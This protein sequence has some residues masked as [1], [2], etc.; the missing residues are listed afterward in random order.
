MNG[1]GSLPIVERVRKA[2]PGDDPERW[3]AS[4]QR[5]PRRRTV[6]LCDTNAA[7][8]DQSVSRSLTYGISAVV[9]LTLDLVW[10]GVLA[11]PLYEP[12]IGTLLRPQP[13][14]VAAALFYAVYLVGVNELVIHAGAAASS[15]ARVAARG[16]LL[17]VVAY[18][19]FDL[20]ALAVLAGWSVLVTAV[21]IAWGA[22]LTAAT[23]GIAHAWAAR[24][25][26]GS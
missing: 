8:G 1:V 6:D 10:L 2:R 25:K 17:G 14:L 18:S 26:A 4:R 22:I 12:A 3:R 13:N 24:A 20:T 9:M 11:P 23:A 19:T 21:D 15:S 16:A 5:T 7:G